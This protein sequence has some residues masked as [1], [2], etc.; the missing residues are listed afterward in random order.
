LERL[1]LEASGFD[2]RSFHPH[3]TLVKL[4]KSSGF[5]RE[6]CKVAYNMMIDLHR[7]FAPLKQVT[8][9]MAFACTELAT[10]VLESAKDEDIMKNL[11]KKYGKWSTSR[12]EIVETVLDLLDL[13]T[14]FQKSSIVGQQYNIDQFIQI[15]IKFNHEVESTPGLSRYTEYHE[16]TKT[17]G[18]KTNVKT[19][20]T[21]ITPASPSEVRTN[22]AS[23]A[24]LSPRS[25]GSRGI[26]A[27]GQ[28]GTVRF[29]LDAEQARQEKE[30]VN[31]Y[32]RV[33]YEEYE[34]EV[35]EPIQP[36]REPRGH[37]RP[38]GGRDDRYHQSKRGRRL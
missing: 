35:E 37:H 25:S 16:T 23:P 1:V 17:N 9:T 27:R 38:S 12:A 29:M 13:Y 36:E 4:L 10:F 22:G 20:K 19:P 31:E 26:G 15:R 5:S 6:V 34:I 32:H 14:H 30:A 24:T 28:D 18:I 33:E 2:F 21:P 8:T 11:G 3:E 7:T